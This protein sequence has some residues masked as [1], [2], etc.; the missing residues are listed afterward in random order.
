MAKLH[1]PLESTY[2]CKCQ[3]QPAMSKK[4]PLL[5]FTSIENAPV[6]KVKVGCQMGINFG[7]SSVKSL[8][9]KLKLW[10]MASKKK[11]CYTM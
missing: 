1:I 4:C 7:H 6:V 3:H 9:S 2:V 5:S 8:G 11:Q 10:A